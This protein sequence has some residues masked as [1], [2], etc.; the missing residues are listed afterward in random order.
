[1]FNAANAR[2]ETIP[3]EE[4]EQELQKKLEEIKKGW[5]LK[6]KEMK[7]RRSS[8]LALKRCFWAI[9]L[10]SV[11]IALPIIIVKNWPQPQNNPPPPDQYKVALTKA[12]Q[13]FDA[14]MSGR[15]PTSKNISWRQDSGLKD[16]FKYGKGQLI[17]GYYDAGNNMKISFPMAFSMTMLSWSTIEYGHKYRAVEEYDHIRDIIRW[18]TDY[19]LLTFDSSATT[20]DHIVSQVG[21]ADDLRCWQRPEDM[22]YSR[23]VH[24]AY[25]AAD[26]A[27]EVAAALASASIV[28]IDDKNY[29]QKLMKGAT[30]LFEF[31][32]DHSKGQS[33]SKMNEVTAQMYKSSG[34]YDE[35]LWDAS[36]MFY[37]SGN[38]SYLTIATNPDKHAFLSTP[39]S[40]ALSWDNKLPGARLL[41][42]RLRIFLGPG[43]PYEAMLKEYHHMNDLNMCAFLKRF[44]FYNFT[45]G[46]LIQ[47]NH[48]GF[49][50]LQYAANAAFIASVYVDYMKAAGMPGWFCGGGY[51]VADDVKKFATSQVDYI[52]GA[53]P[54]NMSYV[55]G[56]G[57][58][59]PKQVH[60]RGSSI[61]DDG[62]HYSCTGGYQW[63]DS[64]KSNPNIIVGAMVGG[65][66]GFDE[67]YDMRKYYKYT[68]PSLAGNA[69]LVAALISLTASGGNLVD[70]N[71]MFTVIPPFSPSS[72][73]PPPPWK[74]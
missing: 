49:Q 34:F 11:I 5:I 66:D 51:I 26:L 59:H 8:H 36:W 27:G 63:R 69:G 16:G 23:P 65:P 19:L 3:E 58:K 18:G 24:R 73:Q 48:R 64:P 71:T 30:A 15:L 9:V 21:E 47:M 68:E 37:A 45:G 53:N 41:L 54:M 29:S 20:I 6:P 31:A 25:E 44:N 52:L 72:P 1:M 7:R 14:Q 4:E 2:L 17:G 32:R 50:Y 57:E 28:F 67:F 74:P 13:F 46:G 12:L 35:F 61:P 39:E 10:A 38:C 40:R 43:Y 42:I 33:D 55:V 22:A 56:F 60:H 70:K 62:Y